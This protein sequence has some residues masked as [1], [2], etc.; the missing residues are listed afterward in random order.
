MLEEAVEE[1]EV[2]QAAAVAA[3]RGVF[4]EGSLEGGIAL[5]ATSPVTIA[6]QCRSL[7]AAGGGAAA[8]CRFLPDYAVKTLASRIPAR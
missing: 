3:L 1:L 7:Q 2:L 4:D 8:D 5:D 6:E